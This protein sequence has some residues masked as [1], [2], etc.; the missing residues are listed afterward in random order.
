M[1][2]S[3]QYT[4][5]KTSDPCQELGLAVQWTPALMPCRG[6]CKDM[7]FRSCR[8]EGSSTSCCESHTQH[9]MPNFSTILDMH[10]HLKG[11]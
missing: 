4:S 3:L 2:H 10:L 6:G 11:R 1:S 8:T 7:F 5:A 9:G